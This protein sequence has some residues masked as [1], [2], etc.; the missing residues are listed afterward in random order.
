MTGS[1]SAG[2]LPMEVSRGPHLVP[3]WTGTGQTHSVGA[4]RLHDAACSSLGQLGVAQRD[5]G[6]VAGNCVVC[7]GVWRSPVK[8]S[9]MF[10]KSEM[11]HR[12][13]WEAL[14]CSRLGLLKRNSY[15]R[16]TTSSKA[17]AGY[18]CDLEHTNNVTLR[19]IRDQRGDTKNSGQAGRTAKSPSS[20][21]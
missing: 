19:G 8:H 21:K 11:H 10:G 2:L 17:A 3:V 1:S 4:E 14:C 5:C 12:L 13:G 6:G 15:W 20:C 9:I 16:T 7:R 18:I